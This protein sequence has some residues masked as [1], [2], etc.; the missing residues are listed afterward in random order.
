MA[1]SYSFDVVSQVDLQEVDNAVN[2]ARKEI[3][4]RYDFKGFETTIDVDLKEKIITLTTGSDFHLKAAADILLSRSIKRGIP[5]K[6][7]KF[8]TVEQAAGSASRQKVSL[9]VGLSKDDAKTIVA[10]I[11]DLKLK[12]QSQ[13]MDD[14]VRVSGKDKDELQKVIQALRDADFPFAMQFVNYR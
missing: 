9:Q 2:Q 1:Q 4:Q 13:I 14:Q 12:I 6:A 10:H 11:K 3:G 5:A 7:M 8:G